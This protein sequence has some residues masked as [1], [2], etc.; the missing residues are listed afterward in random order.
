[1]SLEE[2][3]RRVTAEPADFLGL[4]KKGRIAPGLDADV[5]LF[6]LDTVK[7]CPL[8][9]VN[10]LPG[11]KPRIIERAEGVAYTIVGGEVLFAHGQHQGGYPGKVLRSFDA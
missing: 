10:D 4:R 11:G 3:V 8:E 9:W 1:L 6:D 7:P 2:A 5:V